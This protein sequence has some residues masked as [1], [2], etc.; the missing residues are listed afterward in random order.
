MIN[1]NFTE[2]ISLQNIADL[3]YSKY[4]QG[5]LILYALYESPYI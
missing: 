5:Y 4:F 3:G 1:S 2:I